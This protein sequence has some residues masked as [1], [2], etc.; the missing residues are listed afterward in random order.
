[1]DSIHKIQ[2]RTLTGKPLSK[3]K[4]NVDGERQRRNAN[5]NPSYL[6]SYVCNGSF[7]RAL[8]NPSRS[9]HQLHEDNELK[10]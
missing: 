4:G 8:S 5:M 2:E 10:V 1:M 7:T 6:Q 3:K 9:C